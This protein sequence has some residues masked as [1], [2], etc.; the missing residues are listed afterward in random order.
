MA[1]PADNGC[2]YLLNSLAALAL[3]NCNFAIS[4]F[5]ACCCCGDF[6]CGAG[7]ADC[8][9]DCCGTC[10]PLMPCAPGGGVA[11]LFLSSLRSS[12]GCFVI[13]TRFLSEAMFVLGRCC[14]FCKSGGSSRKVRSLPLVRFFVT[15]AECQGRYF[16][17]HSI[18]TRKK[19]K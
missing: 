18:F 6:S 19:I 14:S 13:A 2:A 3:G 12:C 10:A 11:K 16:S 4:G 17:N 1:S 9:G 15:T 5:C 8:A 7:A